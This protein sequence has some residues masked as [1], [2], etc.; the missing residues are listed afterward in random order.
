MISVLR[1]LFGDR[2]SNSRSA[3]SETVYMPGLTLY[4]TPTCPFCAKV[5]WALVKNDL[6]IEKKN[7]LGS[8]DA[9]DELIQGGGKPT[10]PCLKIESNGEDRWL[11]ESDDIVAY[12]EKK[13]REEALR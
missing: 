4:Y 2:P 12:L 11:Y 8:S 10:V 13:A 5:Q 1:S 3:D 9:R 6:V 7:L